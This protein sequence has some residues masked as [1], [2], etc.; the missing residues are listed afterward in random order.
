MKKVIHINLGGKEFTIDHDAYKEMENYLNKIEKHFK[1]SDGF[2]GIIYDIE[3]RMGELFEE[4]ST[5]GAIITME[6]LDKV[7][8]TMGSPKDFS[9]EEEIDNSRKKQHKGKKL[10]RNPEEKIIGGVASGLSAYFGITDPIFVR[11]FFV[12][13][14]LSGGIGMLTYIVLWIIVPKAKTTSDFLAMRGEEI[15]IDNI[16]KSVEDGINDIKNKIDDISDGFR[17]KIL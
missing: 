15:N 4:D 3:V 10:F 8:R 13:I 2:E 12:L 11:L 9:E 7:K 14:T 5:K 1:K 17:T 6:K 16:A